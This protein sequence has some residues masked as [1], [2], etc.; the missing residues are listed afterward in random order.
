MSDATPKQI[1][2]AQVAH[3]LARG[4]REGEVQAIDALRI[5][6]TNSAG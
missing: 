3:V 5:L 2:A 6:S 4:V 1:R